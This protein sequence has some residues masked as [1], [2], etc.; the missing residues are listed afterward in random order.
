MQY[1]LASQE[2][3]MPNVFRVEKR[4]LPINADGFIHL[5]YCKGNRSG[6]NGTNGSLE[7]RVELLALLWQRLP[8][9]RTYLLRLYNGILVEGEVDPRQK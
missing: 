3:L 8:S 5:A 9:R 4:L 6:A 2:F 7:V 1:Y